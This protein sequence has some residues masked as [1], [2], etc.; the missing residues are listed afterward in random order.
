MCSSPIRERETERAVRLVLVHVQD[1]L[2]KLIE[3]ADERGPA[4]LH[5]ELCREHIAVQELVDKIDREEH[6]R[7]DRDAVLAFDT[8]EEGLEA[9]LGPNSTT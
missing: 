3:I 2:L 8:P 4:Y 1:A 7:R 9:W 6:L 5:D